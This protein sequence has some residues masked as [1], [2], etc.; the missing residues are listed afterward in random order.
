MK[1]LQT[2]PQDAMRVDRGRDFGDQGVKGWEGYSMRWPVLYHHTS[3]GFR[4][5]RGIR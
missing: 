2:L 1:I 5:I 3:T 4:L